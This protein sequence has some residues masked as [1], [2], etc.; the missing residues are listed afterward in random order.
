ML[1]LQYVISE[2]SFLRKEF[3]I[4]FRLQGDILLVKFLYYKDILL[5]TMWLLLPFQ[6]MFKFK[7]NGSIAYVAVEWI[8]E[9]V[10]LV[11]KVGS[12]HAF[13]E[14]GAYIWPQ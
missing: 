8:G 2:L 1:L 7:A 11:L 12:T 4:R 14:E 6:G 13:K 5:Y 10:R 9:F 3:W